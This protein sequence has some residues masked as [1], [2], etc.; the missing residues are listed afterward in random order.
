MGE[1]KG[2]RVGLFGLQGKG[3]GIDDSDKSSLKGRQVV[4]VWSKC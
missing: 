4:R 2:E 3:K 1:V